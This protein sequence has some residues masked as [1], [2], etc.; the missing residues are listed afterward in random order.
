MNSSTRPAL[1]SDSA[2]IDRAYLASPRLPT[3]KPIVGVPVSAAS[4][5][6]GPAAPYTRLVVYPFR[7]TAAR[8]MSYAVATGDKPEDV[9][10]TTNSKPAATRWAQ[11]RAL[12][13]EVSS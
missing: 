13:V 5:V 10:H 1:P 3:C 6:A 8:V 11:K 12:T 4:P 7:R 9:V 2:P